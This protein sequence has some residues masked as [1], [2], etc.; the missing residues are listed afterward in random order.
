MAAEILSLVSTVFSVI[1]PNFSWHLQGILSLGPFNPHFPLVSFITLGAQMSFTWCPRCLSQSGAQGS[2]SIACE[3]KG[4]GVS[5][6]VGLP[7][8]SWEPLVSQSEV[9]QVGT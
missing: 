1:F 7:Q 4:W 9:P 3:M 5:G 2:M 6:C 8:F